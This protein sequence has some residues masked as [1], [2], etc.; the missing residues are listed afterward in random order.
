SSTG[1]LAYKYQS[2]NTEFYL[3]RHFSIL[4]LG[5]VVMYFCHLL[6]YTVY[7]RFSKIG[8]F[9]AVPLLLFTLLMG[10][11]INEANRWITLPIINLSFQT[12]DM[13]KV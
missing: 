4:V 7:A 9:V 1:T 5:F 12:S 6:K 13:A 10:S 8:L 11:N 2:G 3:I